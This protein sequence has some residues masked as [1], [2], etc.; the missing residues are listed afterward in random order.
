MHTRR[1]NRDRVLIFTE[2]IARQRSSLG[3][4]HD[5]REAFSFDR[6]GLLGY[7]RWA[8]RD[9]ALPHKKRSHGSHVPRCSGHP[10]PLAA[11]H[12]RRVAARLA[13]ALAARQVRHRGPRRPRSPRL[14][15]TAKAPRRQYGASPLEG[16]L[17][18]RTG[19]QTGKGL[20]A[21]VTTASSSPPSGWI[22][23]VV[24]LPVNVA[25]IAR[26]CRVTAT[27]DRGDRPKTIPSA[28]WCSAGLRSDRVGVTCRCLTGRG[29]ALIRGTADGTEPAKV[30]IGRGERSVDCST[31]RSL[32][33][34]SVGHAHGRNCEGRHRDGG[35]DQLAHLRSCDRGIVAW[36]L[37]RL[38]VRADAPAPPYC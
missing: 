21:T 29:S 27:G 23:G 22:G 37:T 16:G 35:D 4:A 36:V 31:C 30:A 11:V 10:G 26:R 3:R 19:Y 9:L 5:N 32:S 28:S 17:A 24:G 13:A 20:A 6:G 14:A 8:G 38:W 1:R 2:P 33:A 34:S 15:S 18:S 7:R 25:S 12:G